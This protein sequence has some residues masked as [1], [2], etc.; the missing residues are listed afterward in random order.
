MSPS[1]SEDQRRAACQAL[2]AKTGKSSPAKLQGAAKQMYDSMTIKQLK[3]FCSGV[4]H[5]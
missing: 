4:K 5:G 2:S 3:E 1:V